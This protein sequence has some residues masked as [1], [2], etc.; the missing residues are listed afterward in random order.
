MVQFLKMQRDLS[1]VSSKQD[2]RLQ[3]GHQ[4]S[5]KKITDEPN[6]N[7]SINHI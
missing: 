1:K 5:L 2:V 3:K 6:L 4:T 7:L